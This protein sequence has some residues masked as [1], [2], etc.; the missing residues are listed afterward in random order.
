MEFLSNTKIGLVRGLSFKN[1]DISYPTIMGFCCKQDIENKYNRMLML[2]TKEIHT[3]ENML[4]EKRKSSYLMGRISAKIA[5]KE[6]L[7]LDNCSGIYI[8]NGI[9]NQPVISGGIKL[10]CQLSISHTDN[11]GVSIVFD[12]RHPLGI[13]IE[14]MGNENISYVEA[15][16]TPKERILLKEETSLIAW[17]SKEALSKCLKTGLTLPYNWFE[18]EHISQLHEGLYEVYFSDYKQFKAICISGGKYVIAISSHV[19]SCINVDEL[20]GLQN[21]LTT[22]NN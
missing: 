14:D 21:S 16:L 18:I 7:A 13:D 12:E 1:A 20:L 9:F 8:E 10:N 4:H 6:Y 22:Y 17:T 2:N 5:L 11:I 3:A 19:A 15:L